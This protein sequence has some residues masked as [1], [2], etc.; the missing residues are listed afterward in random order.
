M[1]ERALRASRLRSIAISAVGAVLGGV[2]GGLFVVAV[3][4]LV[5]VSMDSVGRQP[6]WALITMPLLGLVLAVVV[7]HVLGVTDALPLAP[8]AK[9]RRWR[10]FPVDS[11]RADITG[12]VV[13]TA[14]HEERFPWRLLPIRILAIFATVGLGGAMG[15]E[16][17]AAYLGDGAGA[18]LGDR[19]RRWRQLLRPAALGGGAA[20][21]AALMGIALVGTLYM[22]EIGRRQRAP[23]SAERVVAAVIG[24]IIGWAINDVF[25]VDLIRLIV[26][27]VAP[28][29]L[30]QGVR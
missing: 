7:L 15:T 24:G 12:D 20:G 5:K 27:T 28:I 2:L 14:G 29:D 4:S 1:S 23:F 8:G 25:N 11:H 9:P 13:T 22:L 3:I 18:A 30:L 17:P 21:V 6:H 16:A 19:G 26:P 10:T